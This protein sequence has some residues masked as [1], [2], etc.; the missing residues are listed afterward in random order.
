MGGLAAQPAVSSVIAGVS[1]PEQVA[2]NADAASWQ[3][4]E[5]DLAELASIGRPTQS[6]TTFAPA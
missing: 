6:Y 5:D 4:T 3:P 2:A 1:R